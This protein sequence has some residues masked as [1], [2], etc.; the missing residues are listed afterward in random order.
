ME[1]MAEDIYAI[2]EMGHVLVHMYLLIDESKAI[3][4]DTGFGGGDLVGTIR[5]LTDKP[6]L[7]IHTHADWDHVGGDK[8]FPEVYFHKADSGYPD[9]RLAPP[10]NITVKQLRDGEVIA[11][12]RFTLEVVHTPGHT[13]GSVAFVD[14]KRRLLFSGDSLCDGVVF[15]RGEY[16]DVNLYMQSLEN[17]FLP[18]AGQVDVIYPAHDTTPLDPGIIGESIETVRKLLARELVGKTGCIPG[19][20][21][22]CYQYKRP[23]IAC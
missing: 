7:V 23:I 20:D 15:M 11:G 17:K 13:M 9:K 3:L 6:L 2:S 16:R 5:A 19:R 8:F 4:I 14:R 12:E 22:I 10:E 21:V 18:L 1:R